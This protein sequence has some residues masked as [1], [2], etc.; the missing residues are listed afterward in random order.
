MGEGDELTPES[1]TLL[2][3]MNV[4]LGDVKKESAAP[5]ASLTAIVESSRTE[6]DFDFGAGKQQVQELVKNF[7][8]VGS[9]YKK[10]KK[11]ISFAQSALAKR[12]GK[13]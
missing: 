11:S 2:G 4:Q 7:T 12:S 9:N 3:E 6:S 5:V 1:S 13:K 10:F 8:R